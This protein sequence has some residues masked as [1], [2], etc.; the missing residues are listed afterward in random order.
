MDLSYRPIAF[1]SWND[2]LEKSELLRQ[3]NEFKD[4]GYGG[5]VIHARGGLVTEYLSEEWFRLV[6]AVIECAAE[7]KLEVWLYDEFGWPSGFAGGRVVADNPSYAMPRLQFGTACP[8]GAELYAEYRKTEFGYIRAS[9][10]DNPDMVAYITRNAGYVNLLDAGAVDS[11]IS[12]TH[13]QYKKRFGQYFGG[14]VKGFFTDEPQINMDFPFSE[15]M[16]GQYRELFGGDFK[17]ELWRLAYSEEFDLFRYRFYKIAGKLFRTNFTQKIAKWCEQNGVALTGHFS[18]EDGLIASQANCGLMEHYAHMQV[19][20]IDFLGRRLMSPVALESI[21]SAS[22]LFSK[23][24]TMAEVFGCCGWNVNFADMQY[25]WGS[26]AV[27]GVNKP[28]LHL[29][30]YSMRGARKRDYPAFYSYQSESW[31]YMGLFGDWCERMNAVLSDGESVND[32][33][34]LSPMNSVLSIGL[35]CA[36]ARELSNSWRIL[37]ESLLENQVFFD[38]AE[39]SVF[40]RGEV[41]GKRLRVLAGTYARIILPECDFIEEETHRL[42]QSAARA[43]IEIVL[44]EKVPKVL[45]KDGQFYPFALRAPVI[46]NRADLW[47]KYCEATNYIR[48]V[49]ARDRYCRPARGITVACRR[50]KGGLNILLFNREPDEKELLLIFDKEYKVVLSCGMSSSERELSTEDKMMRIVLPPRALTSLR[51]A[52][53]VEEKHIALQYDISPLQAESAAREA[54]NIMTLDCVSVS[55][56]GIRYGEQFPVIRLKDMLPTRSDLLYVKYEWEAK[57]IPPKLKLAAETF[58]AQDIFVNGKPVQF[59]GEWFIDRSI[60]TAD[61]TSLARIGRNEAVF[62]YKNV[63]DDKREITFETQENMRTE[64]R[65]YESIYL[66]GDFGVCAEAFTKR[67]NYLSVGGGFALTESNPLDPAEELTR[68]GLWFYKGSIR[69]N[70]SFEADGETVRRG[71]AVKARYRG[72]MLEVW[73]N[74][75]Y[76]GAIASDADCVELPAV[77]EGKNELTVRLIISLRN[78]LGPHHHRAGEPYVVTPLSFAGK[79]GSLDNLM[80]PMGDSDTWTNNYN[81][82]ENKIDELILLRKKN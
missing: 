21:S 39:E 24:Y 44:C 4:K 10:A 16:E 64:K 43:G 33:L 1:W 71:A 17:S 3:V 7:Q 9:G 22:R 60:R 56:D 66:L 18:N 62:V 45:G 70:C 2:S 61:I 50:T 46:Y 8:S 48:P 59:S 76:C 79:R 35:R 29:S 69:C 31:K 51:C 58:G 77:R 81:F 6:G 37:I 20:A 28:C 11:F 5:F 54:E 36:H 23:K 80:C 78:C 34:V 25:L 30:A 32:T 13:E 65:E 27:M 67:L 73:L 38:V 14:T 75:E 53:C 57:I 55:A 41:K 47:R 68:Q 26:L 52:E 72:A 12:V 49:F 74:G 63:A 40:C 15:E 19:P 42:L 82:V